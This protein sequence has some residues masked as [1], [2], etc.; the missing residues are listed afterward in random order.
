MFN[1]RG[2]G[3]SMNVIVVTILCLVVL[4]V[5][6]IIFVKGAD[7]AEGVFDSCMMG[8]I[9]V[10]SE[11]DC[12][13]VDDESGTVIKT[14]KKCKIASETSPSGEYCCRVNGKLK[15]AVS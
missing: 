2:D 7:K 8:S 14:D 9:C 11:S 1:K 13:N 5:L 4:I 3:L 10:R 12:K 15:G 6:I